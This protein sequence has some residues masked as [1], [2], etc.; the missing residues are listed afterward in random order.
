MKQT[1]HHEYDGY[2][3]AGIRLN[4][5]LLSD[6][7]YENLEDETPYIKS[8]HAFDKAHVLML[9]ENKIIPI[10][11]AKAILSELRFMDKEGFLKVRSKHGW[12][13]HSGEHYLIRKLGYQV[14]GR[15]HLARSSGDLG[16]VKK[17]IFLR[18]QILETLPLMIELEKVLI[19]FAIRHRNV[20]IPESTHGLHAQVTTL[21]AYA[22][23][24]AQGLDR[25]IERFSF[26]YKNSNTSPAGA[27]IGTGSPFPVNRN[28]TAELLGFDEV[29]E[30]TLD[31]ILG[32]DDSMLEVYSNLAILCSHTGRWADDLAFFYS[33]DMLLIDLPDRFCHTSSIMMHKKNPVALEHI[34]STTTAA[35]GS[36]T[37]AFTDSK[38]KSGPAESGMST[39]PLL[40]I[41]KLARR[42]LNWLIKMLPDITIREEF[43]KNKAK[44]RWAVATEIA[45]SIVKEKGYSWRIAH[46]CVGTL[47]RLAEERGIKSQDTTTELLDEAALEYFGKP[48]GLTEK[49]YKDA[50]SP[51]NSV[52]SRQVDGGPHPDHTTKIGN[53][54][55]KRLIPREKW[56]NDRIQSL[57]NSEKRLNNEIDDFIR[58]GESN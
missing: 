1:P 40:N 35:I 57:K 18:D 50:L 2:R 45:T 58:K 44:S 6:V 17:Q 33:D 26:S 52:L 43:V 27:A 23:M 31:A 3:G 48:I 34:R 24:W 9:G 32:T 13:M 37:G 22:L 11:D 10:L 16:Q 47:V 7:S 30:S 42:D 49:Q 5:P 36:L 55:N 8:Y 29:R 38:S 51:L 4:E 25:D 53:T 20:I 21:G 54:L 41:F 15:I 14:G 12:G 19:D 46:Q 56:M 39:N 28:R